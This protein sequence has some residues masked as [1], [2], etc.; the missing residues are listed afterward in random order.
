M[1]FGI[2][3]QSFEIKCVWGS[4]SIRKFDEEKKPWRQ[5]Q[6]WPVGHLQGQNWSTY[7]L[8]DVG[9]FFM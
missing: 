9:G 3:L 1:P 4:F 8:V 2:W 7:I 6:N 5:I